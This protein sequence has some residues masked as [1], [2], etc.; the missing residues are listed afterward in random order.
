MT[1]DSIYEYRKALQEGKYKDGMGVLGK[2]LKRLSDILASLLGL[3]VLMPF[4]LIIILALAV[5]DKG[6]VFFKQ[7]RL[8]YK[9][10]KFNIY[11]YRT[12]KVDAEA[13]GIPRLESE[14]QAQLT[15]VGKWLRTYHLDELPQLWNV[16]KG[17]MSFVGPRPERQYFIDQIYDETEDYRYIYLMRPGLCSRA[18][19]YN[20]YT[21]T[22][23]K[24]L[25]RLQMD[26]DY[27]TVR[28]PMEDIRIMF[29]TF[30]S[31]ITGRKF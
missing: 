4:Q 30:L 24:M 21:D 14:R 17:D 2:F 3:I 27:L 7:E 12:M 20:G 29:L 13:N 19:L 8:G 16:L 11:K 28:T 6:P 1:T 23:A 31:M 10:R 18:A 5:S 9:G 22:M 26:L 25:K 15:K